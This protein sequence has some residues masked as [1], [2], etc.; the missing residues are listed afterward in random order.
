MKKYNDELNRKLN[1]EFKPKNLAETVKRAKI[2]E[3][4]ALMM[5]ITIG[6]LGTAVMILI[7]FVAKKKGL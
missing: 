2:L 1:A 7:Y 5:V 4:M 6:I 3:Q